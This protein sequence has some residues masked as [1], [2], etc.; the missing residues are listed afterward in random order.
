MHLHMSDRNGYFAIQSKL[1][2]IFID[3]NSF[4][5]MKLLSVAYWHEQSHLQMA[6][7]LFVCS[8]WYEN[9]FFLFIIN[10]HDKPNEIITICHLSF[11]FTYQKYENNCSFDIQKRWFK[12]NLIVDRPVSFCNIQQPN[13][14]NKKNID[15][16]WLCIDS[17]WFIIWRILWF[18]KKFP[19]ISHSNSLMCHFNFNILNE[20][21]WYYGNSRSNLMFIPSKR[22]AKFNTEWI[23]AN[24]IRRINIITRELI[25]KIGVKL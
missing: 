17:L 12:I 13:E 18:H 7:H 5:T 11:H 22:M 21:E 2:F 25:I 4:V 16:L 9:C 6:V 15:W 3:A 23:L 19:L 8:C 1:Q 14:G 20:N 10:L 24:L